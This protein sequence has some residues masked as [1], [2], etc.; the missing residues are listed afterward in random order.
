MTKIGILVYT[1]DLDL[2]F[3]G[4][5]EN[6]RKL[7]N[8]MV[9][10]EEP[11]VG[12]WYRKAF[13]VPSTDPGKFKEVRR[14][15]RMETLIKGNMIENL[16]FGLRDPIKR[17]LASERS[18]QDKK[19]KFQLSSE[20]TKAAMEAEVSWSFAT[21]KDT[22][23]CNDKP[24]FRASGSNTWPLKQNPSKREYGWN[25]KLQ[26]VQSS[27][28]NLDKIGGKGDRNT[29]CV[30]TLKGECKSRFLIKGGFKYLGIRSRA[31]NFQYIN[32]NVVPSAL[33][34]YMSL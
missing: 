17:Y 7:L 29:F 6:I 28:T 8:S 21:T 23:D 1:D 19:L 12:I 32:G 30:D 16:H 9:S 20:S 33:H 18:A 22:Q 11:L 3:E 4:D 5:E 26:A 13:L 24:D 14:G 2:S 27:C 15:R 25:G 31:P 34:H 10:V